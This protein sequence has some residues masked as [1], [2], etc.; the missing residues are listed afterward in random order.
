M[1]DRWLAYFAAG[2]WDAMAE[3]L[4]D[5]L[6]NEDRRRVV[7]TGI[8]DGR[9][10]QMANTR[11]M[12]ELWSTNMTRT[13]L[14]TRGR[15]LSLARITLSDSEEQ[16][17]AFLTEFHCVLEISADDLITSIIVFDLDDIDAAVAELDAR[18]LAG[19]ASAHPD[20]W[21]AITQACAALSRH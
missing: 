15:N 12:A 17:A 16:A 11:A 19:E 13:V 10:A 21:L 6:S 3:I 20:S 4:A 7:S 2:D 5:N 8:F 14:A 1:G 18:Y 9:D